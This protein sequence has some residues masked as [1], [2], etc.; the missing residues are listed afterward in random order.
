[1]LSRGDG[2]RCFSAGLKQYMFV[3]E[4][5]NYYMVLSPPSIAL[6]LNRF[7]L[8]LLTPASYAYVSGVRAV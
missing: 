7:L 8:R 6:D 2:E 1:M 3:S 4:Q 5:W